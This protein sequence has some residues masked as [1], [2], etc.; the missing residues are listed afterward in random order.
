MTEVN[1]P[2]D[3]ISRKSKGFGVVTFLLPEHAVK[4]FQELDGSIQSGRY[5]HLLP[6]KPKQ[7]LEDKLAD[8]KIYI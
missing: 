5:L 6:A 8:G 2:I 4:A 1:I 7:T 3:F